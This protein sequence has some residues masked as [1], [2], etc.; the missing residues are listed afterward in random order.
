MKNFVK[1]TLATL[2]G[3]LIFGFVSMFIIIATVGALAT[4]GESQPVM[5][6]KAVLTIDMSTMMLGE[7]TKE[8]DILASL[9]GGG[10]MVAPLGIYSAINDIGTIDT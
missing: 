3:L 4:L 5:P 6:A 2:T 9:Q 10:E 1:M 8:T 7:Q